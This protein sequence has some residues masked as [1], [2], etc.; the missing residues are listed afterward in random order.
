MFQGKFRGRELL[1]AVGGGILLGCI[2][3]TPFLPFPPIWE[4]AM[5]C[6]VLTGYMLFILLWSVLMTTLRAPVPPSR[7]GRVRFKRYPFS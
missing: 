5:V 3:A 7:V 1:V 2:V 4:Q 6:V